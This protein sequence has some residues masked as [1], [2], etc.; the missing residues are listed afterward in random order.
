MTSKVTFVEN[1]YTNGL[2]AKMM[3]N[4]TAMQ[5]RKAQPT[6]YFSE[7]C[8]FC[9]S[10]DVIISECCLIHPWGL[11]SSVLL[12]KYNCDIIFGPCL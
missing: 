1:L 4:K 7:G 12:V 5:K 8:A 6:D 2:H 9:N 10:T 11:A 3:Q